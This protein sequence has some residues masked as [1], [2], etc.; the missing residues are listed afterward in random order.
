MFMPGRNAQKELQEKQQLYRRVEGMA[1][2]LIPEAIRKDC[3]VSVQEV[4]CGDPQCS[5][6][7]VVVTLM[8]DRY[9]R[10]E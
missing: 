10:V 9:V 5:P 1:E 6:I 2:N 3:T 8:F 7:D 4:Q